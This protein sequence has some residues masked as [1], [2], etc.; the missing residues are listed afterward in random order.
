MKRWREKKRFQPAVFVRTPLFILG[1]NH[2][3]QNRYRWGSWG[4]P[5][6]IQPMRRIIIIVVT[7]VLVVVLV[8]CSVIE[9]TPPPHTVEPWYPTKPVP[10]LVASF[11]GSYVP[12]TFYNHTGSWV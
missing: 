1:P 10:T 6:V 8:V 3:K 11:S 2:P 12:T 5:N 4:G 7:G 9:K